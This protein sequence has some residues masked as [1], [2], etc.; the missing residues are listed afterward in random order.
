MILKSKT[1]FLFS[2][3]LLCSLLSDVP[4]MYSGTPVM[5][6][7]GMNIPFIDGH[8]SGP[9]NISA[10]SSP[11]SPSLRCLSVQPNGDVV[12]SWMVTDTALRKSF[13]CYY[14][15]SSTSATGPFKAIDS[16]FSYTVTSYTHIGAS[17]NSVSRYYYI[18]SHYSSPVNGVLPAADS[19][20]TIF[21]SIINPGDG[22]AR[23]S[24]NALSNPLMPSS[25]KWY[26]IYREYPVG[27]WKQIDS[28]QSLSMI[29]TINICHAH[30]N[31]KVEIGDSSGCTSISNISGGSFVDITAPVLTVMDTVS[32]SA[33]GLAQIGWHADASTD[34]KGYVIYKYTNG[35]WKAIDT[36]FGINNTNWTFP[37]ST[38]GAGSETYGIATFDSCGN[39]SALS[40]IQHTIYLSYTRDICAMSITLTW[41]SF[42]HMPDGT[43]TYTILMGLNGGPMSYAGTT[44]AGDTTFTVPN[45]SDQ[46]VYC[47]TIVANNGTQSMK[48]RSNQICYTATTPALPKYNYFR[49]ASVLNSSSVKLMAYVDTLANVKRYNFYRGS[50]PTGPFTKVA[51][52]VPPTNTLIW[53]TD[54]NANTDALSYYY[55]MM[56]VDSCDNERSI[57]NVAR[58]ILL[59]ATANEATTTNTLTW[60]N[61]ESWLGNVQ[62]YNI[63][64]AIDG[65]WGGLLANVSPA[66]GVN[67]YSDNVSAFYPTTGRFEY[68]V[69]GLEG[70]GN[71]YAFADSSRSN[72]VEARQKPE[73]YVPNAFTPGGKNPIF[74]PE[75]SF[76]GKENYDFSVFDRWG[77][78]VFETNDKT[79]GWDGTNHGKRMEMGMYIYLITYQASDGQFI[80]I[81]GTVTLLR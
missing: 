10:T 22:T 23:L 31:F 81:K 60:N 6:K 80:D 3:A 40:Q 21:L 71:P 8:R 53:L 15:Y 56:V 50:S 72:I 2:I 62:S 41:N 68:Y 27:T 52:V 66:S 39:I 11:S 4:A 49:T 78:K 64:R 9:L 47:F 76:I 61:Y 70:W 34:T 7:N 18:E 37:G 79:A 58:T 77:E 19:L 54:N 65:V 32:V 51:T 36:A 5:D 28:T 33:G 46:S 48:A 74:K 42:I 24:W 55:H 30:L 35:V 29:D 38:A 57:S 12:L 26:H 73:L 17:A 43:G 14:I 59:E 45:L 63:Y 25:M 13:S 67:T 69:L 44:Q 20:R 16:I 1:F 75:G